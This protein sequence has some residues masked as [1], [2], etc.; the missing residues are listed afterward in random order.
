MHAVAHANRGGE[1]CNNNNVQQGY[2]LSVRAFSPCAGIC[3]IGTS[4][5]DLRRSCAIAT[6]GGLLYICTIRN[7]KN[8]FKTVQ[9]YRPVTDLLAALKFALKT[10]RPSVFPGAL[11]PTFCDRS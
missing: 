11:L 5:T 9:R 10:A 3:T 7:Y 4:R 1:T 6:L 2:V 8:R